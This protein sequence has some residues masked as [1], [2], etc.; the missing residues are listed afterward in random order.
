MKTLHVHGHHALEFPGRRPN[1]DR[2][3]DMLNALVG[4]HF[5]EIIV[6][7]PDGFNE[8]RL[9]LWVQTRGLTRLRPGGKLTFVQGPVHFSARR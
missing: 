5:D 2:H 9:Q 7:Y 8:E 3:I 1:G 6:H 4:E